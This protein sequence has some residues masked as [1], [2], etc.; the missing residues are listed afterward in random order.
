MISAQVLFFLSFGPCTVI[1]VREWIA[2][3]RAAL[4]VRAQ[5]QA[6]GGDWPFFSDPK[7]VVKFVYLPDELI[8]ASDSPDLKRAK[9]ELLLLRRRLWKV[10]TLA[11]TLAVIG[12]LLAI[13][14]TLILGFRAE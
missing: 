8:E 4:R 2:Y 12:F 5:A 14:C 13:G 10:V 6:E 11:I 3:L 1:V 7:Y 9:G